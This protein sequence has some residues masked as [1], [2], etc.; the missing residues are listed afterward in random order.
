MLL[1]QPSWQ[2]SAGQNDIQSSLH[3]PT[4]YMDVPARPWLWE[5]RV[6]SVD[7]REEELFDEERLQ[8][9]GNQGWLLVNLLSLP[10]SATGLRVY[11]HFVRPKEA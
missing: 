9:L 6:L 1:V 10:V 11:Y 5:Y 4:V 7:T 3:I 8:E 2:Q